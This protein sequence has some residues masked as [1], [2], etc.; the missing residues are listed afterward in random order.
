METAYPVVH[1]EDPAAGGVDVGKAVV[2]A[3][4]GVHF[5]NAQVRVSADKQCGDG[6]GAGLNQ[7]WSYSVHIPSGIRIVPA[8]E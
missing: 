3:S 4:P 2:E 7:F 6:P 8:L 5:A 1:A